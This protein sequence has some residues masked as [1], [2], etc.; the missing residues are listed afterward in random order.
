MSQP[1]I[2]EVR[3]FGFDFVPTGWA[4]C[5]G[6][7]VSI[8][9][10]QALFGLLGPKYG[11]NG[12]T[13]FALPHLPGIQNEGSGAETAYYIALTGADPPRG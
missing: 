5:N 2:G 10:N 11:G 12:T 3:A 7:L 8:M 6:A 1:F 13:D 9:E 4:L